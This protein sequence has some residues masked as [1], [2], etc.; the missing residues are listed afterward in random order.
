MTLPLLGS[1]MTFAV[2]QR[3]DRIEQFLR[4]GVHRLAT[5]HDAVDAQALEEFHP[6]VARSDRYRADLARTASSRRA[7]PRSGDGDSGACPAPLSS[8]A[9]LADCAPSGVVIPRSRAL[10]AA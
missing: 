7:A 3:F 5:G 10:S 9:R 4:A 1:R 8:S 6:A 2:G